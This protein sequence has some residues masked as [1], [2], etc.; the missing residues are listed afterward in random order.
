[1][2]SFGRHA[3]SARGNKQ[4]A[5]VRPAIWNGK[6]C[7]EATG[8]VKPYHAALINKSQT[9]HKNFIFMITIE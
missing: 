8:V 2:P 1:L 9:G 6:I 7:H 4:T 5:P 3:N